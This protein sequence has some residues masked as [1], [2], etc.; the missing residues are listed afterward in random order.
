MDFNIGVVGTHGIFARDEYIMSKYVTNKKK[1][2]TNN[3]TRKTMARSFS[4][5][6][7]IRQDD[8]FMSSKPS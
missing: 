5:S 7:G 2:I 8:H 4:W 1:L 6:T 3:T